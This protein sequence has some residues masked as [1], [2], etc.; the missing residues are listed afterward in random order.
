MYLGDKSGDKSEA[1]AGRAEDPLTRASCRR[2][3]RWPATIPCAR[4]T[5]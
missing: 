5:A 1:F 3:H 4:S 2:G